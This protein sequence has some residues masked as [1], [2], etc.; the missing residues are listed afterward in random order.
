MRRRDGVSLALRHINY[1]GLI[2]NQSQEMNEVNLF[3][4][5]E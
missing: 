4:E 2:H 5:S 3:I 1:Y